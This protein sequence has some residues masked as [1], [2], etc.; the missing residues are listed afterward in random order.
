MAERLIGGEGEL[1]E[2]EEELDEV[3]GSGGERRAKPA[4][5]QTRKWHPAPRAATALRN[6]R[7]PMGGM[8]RPLGAGPRAW[9]PSTEQRRS[10]TAA[11]IIRVKAEGLSCT[12]S[13]TSNSSESKSRG[14]A[15]SRVAAPMTTWTRSVPGGP[16]PAEAATNARKR[17]EM[18]LGL[19]PES[20]PARSVEAEGPCS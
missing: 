3:E 12:P 4:G 19:P 10:K 13:S 17:A 14:V 1:E 8:N 18:A 9:S 11:S 16:G 7:L 5:N 2:D 15:D 20:E 6:T